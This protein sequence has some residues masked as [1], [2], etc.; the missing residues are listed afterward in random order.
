MFLSEDD[1]LSAKKRAQ[2]EAM[3]IARYELALENWEAKI[4][5]EVRAEVLAELTAERSAAS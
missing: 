3:N 4:R 1:Y 2:V 5:A